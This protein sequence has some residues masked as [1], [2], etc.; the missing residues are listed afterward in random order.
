MKNQ[1]SARTT[2]WEEVKT[3]AAYINQQDIRRPEVAIVLGS[4]LGPIAE[5]IE[6]VN[7]LPYHQIP[8]CPVS[9]APGHE[10]NLLFG[11][12]AERT[13]IAMQGRFH[14]YEGYSMDQ[15][16]FLIRVMAVLGVRSLI[17]TNAAGGV[18]RA[19]RPGDLMIIT[20]HIGLG[21]VSPLIGPNIED[22]GPRFNDQTHVYD[23]QYITLAHEVAQ[24]IGTSLQSGI[25]FYA[26]GPAYE[27]PAEIQA[28]GRL[29]GDAV[30][31]STVPEAICA[32]HAGIRIFGLS[33]ITNYAAGIMDEPLNHEEVL[34]VGAKVS[35]QAVAL[36]EGMLPY[37]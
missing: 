20:D 34:A 32:N 4:G 17:L 31:M 2:Y 9:T 30:G 28:I 16:V 25:Y 12:L 3:A 37:M 7:L 24:K 33:C 6:D 36:V 22:L 27:T 14:Y 21:C 19:F 26:Q 15:V 18:N 5:R 1:P 23:P 11:S 8:G 10:G 29:G 13:V 35:D